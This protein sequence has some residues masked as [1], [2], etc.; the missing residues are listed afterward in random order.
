[1][2]PPFLLSRSCSFQVRTAIACSAQVRR[3]PIANSG[4]TWPFFFRWLHP[5]LDREASGRSLQREWR[6]PGM[7]SRRKNAAPITIR[8]VE[9]PSPA[10]QKTLSAGQLKGAKR[11]SNPP[12]GRLPWKRSTCSPFLKKARPLKGFCV[13]CCSYCCAG[14][15]IDD[16]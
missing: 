1:M 4:A 9:Q 8:S 3:R 15:Q 6:V 2:R 12:E 13:G 7:T 14:L 10:S 11:Q 5:D 16:R